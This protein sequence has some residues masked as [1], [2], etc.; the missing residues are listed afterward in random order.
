MR[1]KDER[2]R[3]GSEVR[4]YPAAAVLEKLKGSRSL[5]GPL[6]H[7]AATSWARG[8]ARRAGRGRSR[9]TSIWDFGS[10]R[11]PCSV[12]GVAEQPRFLPVPVFG[13]ALSKAYW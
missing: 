3:I 8:A 1:G 9:G 4:L 11:W 6:G 12:S 7:A 10:G 13:I 5:I 2:A